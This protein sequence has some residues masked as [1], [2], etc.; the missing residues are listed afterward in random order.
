MGC[1]MLNRVADSTLTPESTLLKACFEYQ[2][3][4]PVHANQQQQ[5][6]DAMIDGVG[7]NLINNRFTISGLPAGVPVWCT[8]AELP[9]EG[10]DRPVPVFHREAL[11][12][13]RLSWTNRRIAVKLSLDTLQYFIFTFNLIHYNTLFFLAFLVAT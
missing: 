12:R 4:S 8:R 1:P 7:I 3:T 10:R 2:I 13:A 5:L 11:K 6:T 9:A